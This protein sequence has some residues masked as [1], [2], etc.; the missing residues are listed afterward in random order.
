MT[1][2]NYFTS[3]MI[4][5]ALCSC[6]SGA[7][8][9]ESGA[10]QVASGRAVG[11]IAA[12]T[13]VNARRGFATRITQTGDLEPPVPAPPPGVFKLIHY[14]SP[15]GELAAYVTPDPHDGAKHPAIV[16]ITGGDCNSIGEM[17]SERPRSN[18]QSDAECQ[19]V[20]RTH[21][22]VARRDERSCRRA[23]RR[24]RAACASAVF[25]PVT[26]RCKLG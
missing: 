5:C 14:K 16:W 22:V 9:S 18:D 1:T 17:W 15:V 3:L 6:K 23:P 12:P 2:R 20:G 8:Q 13:L 24:R 4:F 25:S 7:T 26:P 19:G 10:T 11:V 21:A